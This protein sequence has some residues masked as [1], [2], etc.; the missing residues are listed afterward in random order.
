MSTRAPTGQV[1]PY[2]SATPKLAEQP[3]VPDGWGPATNLRHGFS[4]GSM[5]RCSGRGSWRRLGEWQRFAG[6]DV[7]GA[8][9]RPEVS[10]REDAS[11][12]LAYGLPTNFAASPLTYCT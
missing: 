12:A 1:R 5:R 2:P 6:A 11:F 4:A 8:I 7:G 3:R 9:A 10:V